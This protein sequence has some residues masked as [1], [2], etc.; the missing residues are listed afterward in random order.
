MSYAL[1][2]AVLESS[3]DLLEYPLG[4]LLL[5]ASI[6]PFLQVAVQAATTHILHHEV[7]IVVRLEGLK[8]LDNVGVIHFLQE[9]DLSADTSLAI[10]IGQL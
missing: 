3:H 6:R 7:H 5:E 9:F 2:V 1:L 4:I 8:D 10:D